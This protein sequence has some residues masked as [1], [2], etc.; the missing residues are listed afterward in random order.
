MLKHFVEILF[1]GIIVSE[2]RVQEVA[3]RNP[4]LITV[5]VDAFA[6]RFF[7]CQVAKSN[8]DIF[9]SNKQNFSP[10]TYFGTVYTLEEVKKQFPEHT[11]LIENMECNGHQKMVRTHRENWFSLKEGD[12]VVEDWS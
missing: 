12:K 1:P 2:R 3:D 11:I 10:F 7:D 8:G 9:V 6:F 4:S 5:P